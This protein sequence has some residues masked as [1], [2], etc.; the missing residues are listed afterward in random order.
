LK[1]LENETK[2]HNGKKKG[3]E[4]AILPEAAQIG[5][6]YLFFPRSRERQQKGSE[7]EAGING[8]I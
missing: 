3:V 7:I 2:I 4:Q 1:R 8:R 6:G 5:M